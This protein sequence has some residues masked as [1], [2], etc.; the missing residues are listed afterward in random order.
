MWEGRERSPQR[1]QDQND[2]DLHP[3]SW[4]TEGFS[5]TRIV[6][7]KQPQSVACGASDDA[8][9]QAPGGEHLE[10]VARVWVLP[11]CCQVSGDDVSVGDVMNSVGMLTHH[12]VIFL[13]R[14]RGERSRW[15]HVTA[16]LPEVK[17]WMCHNQLVKKLQRQTTDMS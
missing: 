14:G 15:S 8:W 12:H 1:H 9:M 2:P 6:N 5:S 13:I 11:R 10:S 4:V 7:R 16:E 17:P 3:S